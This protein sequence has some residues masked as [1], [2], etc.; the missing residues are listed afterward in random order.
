MSCKTTTL[1]MI[2]HG[3]L[4]HTEPNIF[5]GQAD[6][7]LSETG[8]KETLSH[9]TLMK[10]NDIALV[11]SSDLSRTVEPATEYSKFLNCP[12]IVKNEL[13]E[14]NAGDW[15][16]KTYQEVMLTANDYL[17]KRYANPVKVPFPNG[18]SLQDLKKRVVNT[19]KSL[20]KTYSGQNILLIGHAGVIRVIILSY[21]KLSLSKFFCLE[22]DY[23][24]LSTI[25]FFEDG[26]VTLKLFNFKDTGNV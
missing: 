26:N 25:R 24:S 5:T 8:R 21:L 6:I 13:R 17:Q 4:N 18:E 20:L 19:V 1:F 23:G 2:R 16:N 7:P 15:E 10:K 22:V 11:V 12:L 3:R 9:L 14:I